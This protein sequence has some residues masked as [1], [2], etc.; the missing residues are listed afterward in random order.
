V[1]RWSHKTQFFFKEVCYKHHNMQFCFTRSLRPN[2]H[3]VLRSKQTHNQARN[4]LFFCN[5]EYI[6]YTN[7]E[8]GW[9]LNFSGMYRRVVSLVY[10]GVWV[11]RSAPNIRAMT[12][13]AVV[14]RLSETSVYSNETTRRYIPESS[15]LHT[16]LRENLKSHKLVEVKSFVIS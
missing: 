14:L 15:N 2:K 3:L 7:K 9:R 13:G 1:E 10:N 12:M 11:S 4:W 8:S 6:L 5:T 16:C